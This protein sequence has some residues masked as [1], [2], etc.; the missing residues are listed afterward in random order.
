M[1]SEKNISEYKDIYDFIVDN[2]NSM[3]SMGSLIEVI[4]SI[5][6]YKMERSCI[7]IVTYLKDHNIIECSSDLKE[8][9]KD[10]IVMFRPTISLKRKVKLEE[11]FG[12]GLK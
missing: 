4:R 6:G 9:D 12:D 7:A 3:M 1:K 5:T 11:I 2:E 10:S 8:I